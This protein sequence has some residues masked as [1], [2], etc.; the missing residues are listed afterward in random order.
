[1]AQQ[2]AD[3]ER[4][5]AQGLQKEIAGLQRRLHRAQE[6]CVKLNRE[7]RKLRATAWRL[8]RQ[9]AAQAKRLRTLARALEQVHSSRSWRWT[10]PFRRALGPVGSAG[11]TS[12]AAR[13]LRVLAHL[14]R[15]LL[16]PSSLRDVREIARCGLFDEAF[17]LRTYPDVG[18]APIPPLVHYAETG[19]REGRQP[20]P[21]FDAKYYLAHNAD[22]RECVANPLL[23][24]VR[25]GAIAGRDPHPLFSIRYYLA[26]NPD[27]KA[28]GLDPLSHYIKFANQ[29]GLIPHPLFDPTFYLDQSADARALAVNPLTHFVEYGARDGRSPHPLFDAKFYLKE[30]GGASRVSVNPL[31]HYL[32]AGLRES[33]DPHPLFQNSFYLGQ[34]AELQHLGITPL[35][36]FVESGVHE[37][38]QP[39]PLFD[40]IWYLQTYPDVANSGQNVLAYYATRGWKEGHDPSPGFSTTY[41]LQANSDAAA[42]GLCPLEH[43]LRNVRSEVP[44]PRKGATPDDLVVPDYPPRVTL[45]VHHALATRRPLRRDV[46]AA[47]AVESATG[48]IICL[49]HVVPFPPRAVNE[50]RIHRMLVRLRRSGYRIVLVLSLRSLETIED[51]QWG[52]LVTAYG[53][54]VHCEREGHVRHRLDECPDVM[55]ALD[56]SRTHD[57]AA[58][59]GEVHPMTPATRELLYVDR[60]FCHD[61]LVAT[62]L[63]L[64]KSLVPCAVL[65]ENVWMSRALPLLDPDVLTLIDT[66]DVF[67]TKQEKVG[68]FGITGCEVS[69]EEETRRFARARVLLAIQ[70]ERA[71]TLADMAP[72]REVLT[73]G[74][75]I[76]VVESSYWP[77]TPTVLC[78][79][80]DNALNVLGLRDFLKFCWP[81]VQ[82][83]IPD[84]R[85][86]VAGSISRAVPEYAHG[87]DVLGQVNDLG[88]YYESARVVVNP[89]I[90]AIGLTIETVDALSHL[91][92]IVTWPN[93]LEGTPPEMA[94]LFFP[95][96]DWLDFAEHVIAC[97]RAE[98]PPFDAATT[99][100]IRNMLSADHVYAELEA[101]L[102]R[103]FDEPG[104]RKIS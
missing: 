79:G 46:A 36:H 47:R 57:Y 23:H 19:A 4:D 34:V 16:S 90:T 68:A 29:K 53:N 86:I 72:D 40:P 73:T 13:N 75:D 30:C 18:R 67:S 42:V 44:L 64:Q 8:T 63:R 98:A 35:Q 37:G 26:A 93:G 101:R 1:M 12:F 14:A 88:P 89:V 99:G 32:K 60:S 85:L 54:V 92:P 52:E 43:Y 51:A 102:A 15:T 74:V 45:K 58:L 66:H 27:V 78:V 95:A 9:H 71:R 33:H 21:L 97:L 70:P 83:A 61:A 20:H 100:V 6:R 7:L 96:Q 50:Y 49:S 59:L 31:L 28:T 5:R 3:A 87:V 22:V 56:G 94:A 65:T 69:K 25:H 104:S 91:R 41:Y 38:R 76:E 17:Y 77:G 11:P 84:A 24:F 82:S 2:K 48:T 103:F 39:N 55:A 10:A 80:S 62:L 81:D